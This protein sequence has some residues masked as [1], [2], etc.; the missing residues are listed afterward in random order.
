MSRST[1]LPLH[2]HTLNRPGW[3]F[4]R[5][6]DWP[7]VGLLGT[8]MHA[9][10]T[11]IRIEEFL[12]GDRLVVRAEVPGVDPDKDIEVSISDGALHIQVSREEKLEHPSDG[13]FR[14]EFQYGSFA[15]S[16]ALPP[17]TYE[18]EIK[19]TY[20]NGVLEVR[21]PIAKTATHRIEVKHS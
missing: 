8:L 4:T 5:L 12:D 17:G 10:A 14:T 6:G 16:I 9:A 21:L 1:L 18:S 19:A 11:P 3:P 2:T 13:T 15:R 7:D 20:E